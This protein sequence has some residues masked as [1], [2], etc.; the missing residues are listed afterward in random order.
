MTPEQHNR[1]ENSLW[2]IRR[3]HAGAKLITSGKAML[4]SADNITELYNDKHMADLREAAATIAAAAEAHALAPSVEGLMQL[5]E[6]TLAAVE[7]ET[8]R[9]SFQLPNE[10]KHRIIR[11]RHGVLVIDED[12]ICHVIP[13]DDVAQV[14][15]W[16]N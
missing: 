16:R 15:D 7:V 6:L 13:Y 3:V 9:A 4:S 11:K 10:R 12:D 14:Q 8:N 5:A 2:A 1:V